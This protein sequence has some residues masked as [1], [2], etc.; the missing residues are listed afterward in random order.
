M[1][2]TMI[3]HST[4]LIEIDGVR[5]LTDPYFGL[6]GNPAYARLAPPALPRE[7]LRDV[8]LVLISHNH[9]DHTDS[10]FLRSLSH[11]VPVLCPGRV[12]WLT[13]LHGARHLIGMRPWEEKHFG[14]LTI[15]AV[16]ALHITVTIG[17]VIEGRQRIAYFSGDTYYS[18][19]MREIGRRF[20]LDVA[21]IPV[22]TYRI[23][24]TMGERN[25][26][27]AARTLRPTAIVPIHLGL[28]P[29]LPFLRTTHTPEGF[30]RRARSSG[31][32]SAVVVLKEGEVWDMESENDIHQTVQ[33][34]VAST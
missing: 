16:P 12:K 19:F 20:K 10:K 1:R 9:W 32:G 6:W 3:G 5:I 4:V 26:V 31:L 15:T 2:I 13:K 29:R 33:P 23:P 18:S 14:T 17:F 25:A 27:C 21:L 22:T 11:D 34:V 7:Q 28:R 24:L 8:D 30:S